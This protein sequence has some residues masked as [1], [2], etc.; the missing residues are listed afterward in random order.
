MCHITWL[1]I[2]GKQEPTS[3]LHP[4]HLFYIPPHQLLRVYELTVSP[5][6]E[7]LV[8]VSQDYY[9]GMMGTCTTD[10]GKIA[11]LTVE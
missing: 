2:I 7:L 1:K 11:N 3:V 4:S 6:S 8:S 5:G 9:H 10:H